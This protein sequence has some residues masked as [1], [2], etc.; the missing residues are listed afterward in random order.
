MKKGGEGNINSQ[1]L[2]HRRDILVG[3]GEVEKSRRTGP[4]LRVI[5]WRD[6]LSETGDSAPGGSRGLRA[7]FFVR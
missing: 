6:S 1:G 4:A 3:L 5:G 7:A 2:L